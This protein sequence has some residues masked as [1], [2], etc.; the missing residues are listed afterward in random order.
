MFAI[1]AIFGPAWA[2]LLIA[3][4]VVPICMYEL[5][6]VAI[7]PV[8]YGAWLYIHG[9]IGALPHPCLQRRP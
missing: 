9:F 7:A 5:F 3:L 6:R 8:R 2:L 1:P 4:L